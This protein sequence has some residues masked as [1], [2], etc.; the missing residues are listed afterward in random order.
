M[1]GD[2]SSVSVVTVA[3]C[4]VVVAGVLWDGHW[5]P[6]TTPGSEGVLDGSNVVRVSSTIDS[7]DPVVG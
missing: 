4:G 2:C 3:S 6:T 5:P 7:F 1:L